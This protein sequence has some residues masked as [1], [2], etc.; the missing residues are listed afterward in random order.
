VNQADLKDFGSK[1]FSILGFNGKVAAVAE[2]FSRS[3]FSLDG[4]YRDRFSKISD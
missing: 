2:I 1:N 3:L 4:S